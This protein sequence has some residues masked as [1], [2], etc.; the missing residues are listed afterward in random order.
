MHYSWTVSSVVLLF[1]VLAFVIGLILALSVVTKKDDELECDR[2]NTTRATL[3]L[4]VAFVTAV[5]VLAVQRL[6]LGHAVKD[7]MSV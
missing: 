5:L 1:A 3:L 6:E 2:A 7:M 4:L